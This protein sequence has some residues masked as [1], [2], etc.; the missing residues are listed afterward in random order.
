M[1]KASLVP[2]S[3]KSLD[4]I[5]ES[6]HVFF[7]L[8]DLAQSF[9]DVWLIA[10]IQISTKEEEESI[11]ISIFVQLHIFS[12]AKNNLWSRSSY[13]DNKDVAYLS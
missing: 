5:L 12:E 7:P 11:Q 1:N 8:F 2:D 9:K 13:S 3:W 4:K 10:V 6:K